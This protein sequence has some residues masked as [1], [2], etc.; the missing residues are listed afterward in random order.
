MKCAVSENY[1]RRTADKP[2]SVTAA[3]PAVFE[4]N[5]AKQLHG[6]NIIR[7]QRHSGIL[8]GLDGC[9][10]GLARL[11]PLPFHDLEIL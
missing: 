8:A 11:R 1:N 4:A 9:A 6:L 10:T 7:G 5:L 3:G 2:G